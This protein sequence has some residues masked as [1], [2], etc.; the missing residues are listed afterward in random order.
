MKS[1]INKGM[2]T[3][4]KIIIILSAIFVQIAAAD[5]ITIES[6]E[7]D[8]KSTYSDINLPQYDQNL[9]I[10]A[11]KASSLSDANKKD[12]IKNLKNIWSHKSDLSDSEQ[13]DVIVE[14]SFILY[15][16]LGIDQFGVTIQW[17]APSH[18]DLA[19]TAG[20]KMSVPNERITILS[21]EAN[22]PDNWIRYLG[23]HFWFVGGCFITCGTGPSKTQQYA[24]E[25]RVTFNANP[26]DG[27]KKLAWSMH[28]MSDLSNPWHTTLLY[29]QGYHAAYEKYVEDNWNTGY[30]FNKTIQE[31]YGQKESISQY[32]QDDAKALARFSYLK[33]NYLVGRKGNW[34][35]ETSIR[36]T[37]ELLI[38]GLQYDMGL[39][40]Y[41][42]R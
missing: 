21:S 15:E 38:K 41:V 24:N 33:L 35:D 3:I 11:I 18:S 36:Y 8:Q 26:G 10:E 29:G 42:R 13:Q 19:G 25:A 17:N 31:Y 40:D 22:T 16:Y 1:G 6:K 23:D 12:L 30:N 39:V 5:S 27:Y 28:Y 34:N 32:P 14:A 9:V 7:I 4:L 2:G 37:K 20:V